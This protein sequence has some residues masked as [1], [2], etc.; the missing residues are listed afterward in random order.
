MEIRQLKYFIAIAN[1]GSYTA[2]A[3]NLFVTQ[4]TLSWNIQK[5]EDELHTQLL[6]QS[7]TN[8]LGL[9]DTGKLLY[10]K[11]GKI[12]SS[13]E[14]L[15]HTIQTKDKVK[16]ET[17][18]IGITALFVIQYMEEIIRFTSKNPNV[19]LMFVQ[20]G[21]IDIQKKLANDEIDVALCSYPL[22]EPGLK[23]EQLNTS[24]PHYTI[25]VVMPSNH[26]LAERESLTI[27]DLEGHQISAFSKDY[28]LGEILYE[29][30]HSEG[31]KPN[32]IFTNGEWEVLIQ[33]ILATD[34]LAL[35]PH[36]IK[37]IRGGDDLT[38]IPL[39]DKA[40]LFKIGVATRKDEKLKDIA[41]KFI[42]YI[43][44]N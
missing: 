5:L 38:W 33:N 23:M 18:K 7:S 13:L 8:T 20:S 39:D 40:N 16:K 6:Y 30:A 35:M 36:V 41:V 12:L 27:S 14:D 37:T 32:V 25:S 29:R 15:V 31:F 17:L 22:Y 4:P 3:K 28:V 10:E 42:E 11:G 44:E 26:V 9:T 19:E 21:S 24:N 43:K 2:A 1:A 34:S